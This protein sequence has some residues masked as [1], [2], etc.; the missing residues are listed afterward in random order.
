[1]KYD[2][3][4]QCQTKKKVELKIKNTKRKY[5]TVEEYIYLVTFNHWLSVC[6]HACYDTHATDLLVADDDS[7]CAHWSIFVQADVVPEGLLRTEG[8]SVYR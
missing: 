5:S 1:M 2:F 3:K 4:I 6:K 7:N 8:L